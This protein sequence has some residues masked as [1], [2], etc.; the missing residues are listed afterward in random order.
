MILFLVFQSKYDSQEQKED[1]SRC[2]TNN[3]GKVQTKTTDQPQKVSQSTSTASKVVTSD[4]KTTDQSQQIQD[5]IDYYNVTLHS[6]K[7]KPVINNSV[8]STKNICN[9]FQEKQSCQQ[10]SKQLTPL[11]PLGK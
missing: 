8:P 6:E 5:K 7:I 10:I 1:K 2:Q 11:V 9:V 3:F 4:I